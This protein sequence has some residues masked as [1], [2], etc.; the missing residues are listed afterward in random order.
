MLAEKA[1]D[2]IKEESRAQDSL[3]PFNEDKVRQ[4][5]E[6]MRLL[7]ETN[8][9]EIEANQ[10]VTPAIHLRHAAL[11]RNRR[12]LLAY[13]NHRAEKIREMRWQFGAII[14]PEVKTNFCEIEQNFFFN[15]GR[16]LATYM[17]SIGE[18]IGIDLMNDLQPPR[19]LFIAVRCKEDYGEVE[20]DDGEIHVLKKDAQYFLPR[21]LCEHLI[22]Q[23]VLDHV[24][25]CM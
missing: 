3:P 17:R 9:A 13:L 14:P 2:L 21:S 24:P 16:T 8:Q 19:E 25:Q 6:E 11:E 4:V 20:T 10:V 15:Y 5:L 18:G 7:F 1:L 22:R 23:G 12:C